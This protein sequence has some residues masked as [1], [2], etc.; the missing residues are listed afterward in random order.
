MDRRSEG[1]DDGCRR[2]P[3]AKPQPDICRRITRNHNGKPARFLL[4]RTGGRRLCSYCQWTSLRLRHP[5]HHGWIDKPV[6]RAPET[7]KNVLA[8]AGRRYAW[9]D[10]PASLGKGD[11]TRRWSPEFAN[12]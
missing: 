9:S 6:V 4:D 8:A 5:V 7:L 1:I 12:Y 10:L 3:S 11:W 2:R